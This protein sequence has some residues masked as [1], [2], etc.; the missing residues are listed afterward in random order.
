M[1][2]QVTYSFK[3]CLVP[4]GVVLCNSHLDEGNSGLCWA[5]SGRNVRHRES[6]SEL[7]RLLDTGRLGYWGNE[8]PPGVLL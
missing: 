7:R 8:T 5:E 1:K 4:T 6:Y 2:L 3:E